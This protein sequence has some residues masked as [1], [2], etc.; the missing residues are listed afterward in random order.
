MSLSEHMLK[1]LHTGTGKVE[2]FFLNIYQSSS[3]I[4]IALTI[5]EQLRDLRL[6]VS[7]Y[8]KNLCWLR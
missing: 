4:V 3:F 8:S 2:N 1:I 7:I 5:E 6:I